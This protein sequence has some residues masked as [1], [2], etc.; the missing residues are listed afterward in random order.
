M[1]ARSAP[2]N[3]SLRSVRSPSKPARA[4]SAG[5]VKK[6]SRAA[7][8]IDPAVRKAVKQASTHSLTVFV[9]LDS[10]RSSF[11]R[12]PVSNRPGSKRE[13]TFTREIVDAAGA[14][15]DKDSFRILST[16][17]NVGVAT[18]EGSP[19][20]FRGLMRSDKVRGMKLKVA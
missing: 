18:V 3:R 1:P 17:P 12:L 4:S 19:E 7:K 8:Q 16:A 10:A 15:A 9:K 11:G 2:A 6:S 20:V 14:G 5:S 13:R